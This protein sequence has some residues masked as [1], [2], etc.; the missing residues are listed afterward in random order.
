MADGGVS[1]SPFARA[2]A[3]ILL[4]VVLAYLPALGAGFVWDDR[5]YVWANPAVLSGREL[6]QAWFSPTS[7][8]SFGNEGVQFYPV[9]FTSFW[10]EYKLWAA[11]PLGYHIVNIALHALNALL[12][13]TVLTRLHVPGALL[14]AALFAVHPVEVESVAWI[15]ERKNLLAA[16]FYFSALLA[17]VRFVGSGE[18]RSYVLSLALFAA[19]VLSK[20]IAVTFPL[21]LPLIDLWQGVKPSGRRSW[22]LIPFFAFSAFAGLL[23]VH[24]ER[25]GRDLPVYTIA[26]RIVLAGQAFWFYVGKLVWPV[27]LTTLYPRW[28]V[29]ASP[30]QL[31]YPL[32]AAAVVV[33]LWVLRRRITPGPFVAVMFFVIALLPVLGLEPFALMKLTLVADHHQYIA[34]TGLLALFAATVTVVLGAP[35]AAVGAIPILAALLFM[36]RVYCLDYRSEEELWRANARVNPVSWFA[37]Y[38]VGTLLMQRGANDE[39]LEQLRTSLRLKPDYGWTHANLGTLLAMRGEVD[40]AIEHFREQSRLAPHLPEAAVNLGIALSL[41]GESGEAARQYERALRLDPNHVAA[42]FNYG[43]LLESGGRLDEAIEQYS[44]AVKLAPDNE[45]VKGYLRSAIDR[46]A[47][48]AS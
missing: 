28:E 5:E 3:L 29:G 19:A 38:N 47:Q 33:V 22:H 7:M 10:L 23:N 27:D 18:A 14:A 32:A 16:A 15:S 24:W 12:V 8:S 21:V 17:W 36:T 9:T 2:A 26:E 40:Q 4:L 11:N 35:G 30:S 45:D 25:S 46:R 34:S 31:A 6:V 13:W 43:Q 39:A 48:P 42:H 20:T 41:K 37:H 1:F 44:I